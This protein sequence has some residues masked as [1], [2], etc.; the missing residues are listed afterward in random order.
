VLLL[1]LLVIG[2]VDTFVWLPLHLAPGF[3]LGR[4]YAGIDQTDDLA[5]AIVPAVL[6][7]VFWAIATALYVLLAFPAV[8]VL[9]PAANAVRPVVAAGL[10]GILIGLA[11]FFH[12]W[13]AFAMGMSVA[14]T[15]L[16]PGG[17]TSPVGVG[18]VVVGAVAGVAGVVL[19]IG[20]LIPRRGPAPA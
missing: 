2:T 11:S 20:G 19:T 16:G 17:G 5:F 8:R 15:D 18:I 13:S 14:D 10:G 6:W 9:A 4:I 12:W 3:S 7:S 1:V